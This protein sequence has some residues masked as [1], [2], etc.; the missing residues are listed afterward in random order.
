MSWTDG[1]K[2]VYFE[3]Y[4]KTCKHKNVDENESPC[5]ECLQEPARTY[6]HKPDRYEE[7]E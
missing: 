3:Q 4:C 2:E 6:S 1:I 7:K 5:Y